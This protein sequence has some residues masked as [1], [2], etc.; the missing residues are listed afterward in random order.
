[1]ELLILL[2]APNKVGCCLTIITI[3]NKICF[4]SKDMQHQAI[5]EMEVLRL[6]GPVSIGLIVLVMAI[7]PHTSL[8]LSKLPTMLFKPH[9][10][11]VD[12]DGQI[13]MYKASL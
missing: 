7:G 12:L 4:L 2:F 11:T 5:L 3:C 6:L 13:A 9:I 8:K 1:M 10:H